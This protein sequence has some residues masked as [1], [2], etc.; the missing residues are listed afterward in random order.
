MQD[1]GDRLEASIEERFEEWETR[2]RADQAAADTK[3]TEGATSSIATLQEELAE[4]HRQ[5]HECQERLTKTEAEVQVQRQGLELAKSSAKD[6]D[7][8]A[9][10]GVG[11]GAT[12]PAAA[13][14]A[15]PLN[16]TD[17]SL[18]QLAL[19]KLQQHATRSKL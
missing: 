1:M 5:L 18:L 2:A 17:A 14:A 16:D 10:T 6:K 4:V 19:T 15:T 11:A 9:S 8:A 7:K 12:N 3:Q 13:A